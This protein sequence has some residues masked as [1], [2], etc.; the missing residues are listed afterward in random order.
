MKGKKFNPWVLLHSYA[1]SISSLCLF[2]TKSVIS[3]KKT[4]HN[5]VVEKQRQLVITRN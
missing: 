5:Y 3:R 1:P 2:D 4:E